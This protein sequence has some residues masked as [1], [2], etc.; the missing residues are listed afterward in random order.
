MLVTENDGSS[1]L[2]SQNCDI[3]PAQAVFSAQ[4]LDRDDAFTQSEYIKFTFNDKLNAL[5]MGHRDA[6]EAAA[7]YH[8]D[9]QDMGIQDHVNETILLLCAVKTNELA[10]GLDRCVSV[11]GGHHHGVN[12]GIASKHMAFGSHE[13]GTP[14]NTRS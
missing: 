14:G 1:S 9:F 3:L 5:K 8:A 10:H 7:L 12:E 6:L 11:N 13:D 4:E 2:Q